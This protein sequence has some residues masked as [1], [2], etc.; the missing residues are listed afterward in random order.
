MAHVYR[1]ERF[2]KATSCDSL[3]ERLRINKAY[4][5]LDFDGW[6]MERLQVAAGE[7]ILD[8]GCGTGGQS[9]LFAKTV[10]PGGSVSAVDI[11]ADS[12]E[13]LNASLA[14]EDPVQAIVGDMTDLQSL[15]EDKFWT[16]RYDLAQSSYALYY[17]LDRDVVLATM[18]RHLKPEGRLAIFTPQGPHG[19]VELAA[20]YC[21]IPQPVYDSLKFR[22]VLRDWFHSNFQ[23]VEEY[24]F[25]NELRI[26]SA[27]EVLDFYAATTYYEEN[28]VQSIREHVEADIAQKGYFEY[29]KN[30]YLV[31]GRND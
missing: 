2:E 24:E 15:I 29:E 12:V 4:A 14:H 8:V 11:S 30:G 27:D 26:P 22:D 19:L 7:D 6:L 10:R 1:G 9:L 28:A 31:I 20:Q 18:K 5:S 25:H 13:T 21:E 3:K 16:K 23:S 17:A